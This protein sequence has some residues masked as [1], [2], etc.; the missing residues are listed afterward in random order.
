[1][2]M[3]VS[4]QEYSKCVWL[5]IWYTINFAGY[6]LWNYLKMKVVKLFLETSE[7]RQA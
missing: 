2:Q 5:T 4:K 3:T 1:M 6:K 7:A